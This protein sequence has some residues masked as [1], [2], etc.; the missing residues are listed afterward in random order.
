LDHYQLITKFQWSVYWW[1]V[2]PSLSFPPES[3]GF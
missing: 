2:S 1:Y 3:L